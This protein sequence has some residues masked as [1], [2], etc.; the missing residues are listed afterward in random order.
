M[1][2]SGG[3]L[4]V[5]AWHNVEGTHCFPNE[6]GRGARQLG[7]QLDL[8]R[9]VATVVPLPDALRSL[10]SGVPLPARAVALTFDDG[11]R[12]NL[13]A[14]VPLL[15]R[16]GLPATFFLVPAML[17]GR[18]G[19]WWETLAWAASRT[20]RADVR[21]RGRTVPLDTPHRRRGWFDEAAE[22]LK[23]TD[24]ANRERVVAEFVAAL[25]PAGQP[26]QGL[27]LDW[28]GARRLVERGFEVGSHS[29][30]HAILAQETADEQR[31]DLT[32]SRL[33]LQRE[34]GVAVDLLAYPNG[35]RSDFD[36]DTVDAARAAGYSFALTTMTGHNRP[37]TPPYE[38]RRA[39]V[40][41]HHG[42]L[43]VVAAV[44]H[45]MREARP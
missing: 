15:E 41:P 34:L 1:T 6:P 20:R 9:R 16:R 45:M 31:R 35:R 5:F 10:A 29:E 27:F 8:L 24:R 39:C 30:F 3:R 19:A 36:D 25:D 14:A 22:R 42:A 32:D 33:A 26:P 13:D 28:D 18:I 38:I 43:G 17:S 21:W 44:R 40:W 23:L 2:G 4:F 12:D 7:R 11:Y 37:D